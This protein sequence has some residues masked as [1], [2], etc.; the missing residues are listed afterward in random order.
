MNRLRILK[1]ALVAAWVV[2]MLLLFG[3]GG[4]FFSSTAAP[5]GQKKQP[6]PQK[7]V[8]ANPDDYVGSETCASCHDDKDKE[9]QRTPH[10]KLVHDSSWKGRVVGC[11]SC[12]GPG[13]AHVE[14]MTDVVTNGKDPAQV[15]DKKIRKFSELSPKEASE[16]CLACHA[17]R[18]EHN[19]YRRGEH[20]RND[21]GC[22]DCHSLHGEPA[23]KNR[24]GSNAFVSTANAEKPGVANEKMLRS[25]EQQLCLRCHAEQKSQFNQPFHHKVLEGAMKCSDCHNP[26]GGF[27]SKQTRLSTGA[28]A[29]CV[30]CHA[31]KQGPFAYE[32]APVK[33]EGCTACHI[34]HGSQNPRMLKTNNVGQLCLECHSQSHGV[35]GA[36]PTGPVKNLALQYKDCTICHVKIHGSHTS[37]VFFR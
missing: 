34:P 35:G 26:H 14:T 12:H 30:K 2:G 27:E 16:T 37:P 19:N 25:S 18:E 9:F 8:A 32:H 5:D 1:V 6:P 17:G 4:R 24:A 33:T 36:V 3:A 15:A 29:A 28:D 31:D 23:G 21:V 13:K 20:W 7:K 10:A 11:E 22:T